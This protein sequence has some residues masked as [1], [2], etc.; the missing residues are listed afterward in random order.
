MILDDINSRIVTNMKV[1]GDKTEVSTL[2]MIKAELLT[3]GKSTKPKTE[4][5]V[6]KSYLKKLKDTKQLM[7]Q[8]LKFEESNK[9][10]KEI[11]TTESL[12]PIGVPRHLILEAVLTAIKNLEASGIDYSKQPGRIIGSVKKALPE[13]DGDQIKEV[14]DTLLLKSGE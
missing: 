14:L 1:G 4:V 13:S 11:T 2:K 5:E 9:V 6:I 12:L 7:I 8:T 3:N 10:D